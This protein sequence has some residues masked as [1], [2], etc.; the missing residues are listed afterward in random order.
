MKAKPLKKPL[1]AKRV[2]KTKG[3][4]PT[5]QAFFQTRSGKCLIIL[6]SCCIGLSIAGRFPAFIE[7]YYSLG[8]YPFIAGALRIS[9]GWVPFSL[10]DILYTLLGIF[11]VWRLLRFIRT[12]IKRR[13]TRSYGFKSLM[14]TL[15][16]GSVLYVLFYLFWGLNYSRLGIAHQLGLTVTKDYS[17]EELQNLTQN[18][19]KKTNRDRLQLG[20]PIELP[21]HKTLF[22]GAVQSYQHLMKQYPF[23][24]Y[25]HRSIK[26]PVY[27]A[28]GGYLQ[29][30]GYYNP[31][32]GEAQV[33]T[34][35]PGILLPYV[36][37]HEMAHQ[38]G[39][40]TEDEANFVGFLAATSST[41]PIF[42]YST[43]LELFRYANSELWY[44][45]SNMAR[46]NFNQL[47]TLVKQ[48]LAHLKAFF[49]AHENPV[50]RFTTKLYGLFLKAN[51]QPQGLDTYDQVTAWLLAYQKKKP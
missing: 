41:D 18:L 3:K 35:L 51:Q 37:C 17:T 6:L 42:Q 13:W 11:I 40:A 25:H 4:H 23:L 49:D 29:Y 34:A 45:D 5:N 50:G 33:N 32:T 24:A 1:K 21:N 31:F 48:D 15:Y 30:T 14:T 22:N 2:V 7:S 43:H 46:S 9:F 38:L 20:N 47:D 16:V 26:V 27:N 8:L 44:R 39:Y 10:G 28:L 19:L 36:A 12:I